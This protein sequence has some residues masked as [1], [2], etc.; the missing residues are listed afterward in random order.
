MIRRCACACSVLA[1]VICFPALEAQETAIVGASRLSSAWTCSEPLP[2]DYLGFGS[3][4]DFRPADYRYFGGDCFSLRHNRSSEQ[5]Q[6]ALPAVSSADPVRD[7]LEAMGASGFYIVRAREEVLEILREGNSCSLWYAEAEPELVGRFRSLHFQL[8][9]QGETLSRGEYNSGD[10][11]YR[12]PY[13]ARAQENVGNGS[14]ITLNAHGAFFQTH[15]PAKLRLQPGG[16]L[17]AVGPRL[18]HVADYTGGSLNAQVT[19]LLH[20]FGHVVGVLPVDSGEA[21]SALLSTQN[22]ATLLRHCRKQ[23]EASR[24]R[25]ILLPASFQRLEPSKGTINR[26]PLASLEPLHASN[27][28][29]L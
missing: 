8:D 29:N 16:P 9:E 12:E 13:V 23:I 2:E 3:L 27:D 17:T 25:T 14:I 5:S 15:A 24:D 20:E 18:L 4:S 11:S 26:R 7:E 1:A 6:G 10:V 22:T 28:S 21:N 19:T